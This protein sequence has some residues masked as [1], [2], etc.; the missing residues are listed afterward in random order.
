MTYIMGQTMTNVQ[1]MSN[2][3]NSGSSINQD[4]DKYSFHIFISTAYGRAFCNW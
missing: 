2:F 4:H 1:M 3:V